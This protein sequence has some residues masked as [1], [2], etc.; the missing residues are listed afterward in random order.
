MTE[1]CVA[2][3]AGRRDSGLDLA[4]G[5]ASLIMIH[6]HALD[7]WV[8]TT[9]KQQAAYA[10]SRFFATLPLPA[11]LV[12]SGV[13]L[14]FR[15]QV[16]ERRREAAGAMRRTLA[17]RGLQL[18]AVGYGTSA[19]SAWL[20]GVDSWATLWRAD[21]LHVIGL[22]IIVI[23][24]CIPD[25]EGPMDLTRVRAR[26]VTVALLSV[27]LFVPLSRWAV[28]EAARWPAPLQA[29]VGLVTDVPG[30][31]R[32][33]LCPLFTWVVAGLLVAGCC[34]QLRQS[35]PTGGA[36]GMNARP[37]FWQA[38]PYANHLAIAALAIVVAGLA[39]RGT[40]A[41]LGEGVLTRQHPAALLNVLDYGARGVALFALAPLLLSLLPTVAREHLALLGRASLWAYV[42]HIPFCYGRLGA[43]LQAR[44]SV[45]QAL[46]AMVALMALSYGVVWLRL[47]CWPHCSRVLVRLSPG[48]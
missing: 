27:A 12:L 3:A 24:Q 6:G 43:P 22:S 37:G 25:A 11:F 45:W 20:D 17:R 46:P 29:T 18:L 7:A 8:S 15:L 42:F 48:R 23:S 30:I 19:V 14:H 16:A 39:N 13:A 10:V 9:G 35:G 36:A 32:M 4:R 28:A 26:V 38:Y 33:P 5:L 31:T 34:S 21:V 47:N 44:L 40:Y 2:V 1:P 41:W